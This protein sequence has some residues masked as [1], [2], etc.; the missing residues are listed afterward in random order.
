MSG[1]FTIGIDLGGYGSETKAVVLEGTRAEASLVETHTLTRYS[2][3]QETLRWLN[4]IA[5]RFP[6]CRMVCD[7]APP[8]HNIL[9]GFRFGSFH[10]RMYEVDMVRRVKEEMAARVQLMASSK[11]IDLR[12]LPVS[13][14]VACGLAIWYLPPSELPFLKSRERGA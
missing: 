5:D 10:T 11:R 7:N 2:D 14:Q 9:R 4:G 6:D 13:H 3:I 1:P 8:Y 12:E